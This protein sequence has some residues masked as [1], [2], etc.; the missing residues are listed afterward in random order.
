MYSGR[1]QNPKE[2][3]DMQQEIASLKKRN[4]EL[5]DVLLETMVDAEGKE[6]VLHQQETHL[7]QL[8]AEWENGHQELLGEL[9]KLKAEYQSL[10]QKREQALTNITPDSLSAYNALRV[11]K[12]NQPMA[13]LVKGSC[14]VCGVEQNMAVIGEVR[15]GQGFTHCVSCDRIL[16]YQSG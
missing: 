6:D 14:S 16:V 1:V 11:R 3:Q 8:T 4:A 10:R 13:L 15:K 7:Q 9:A 5:E 2:L 12:N